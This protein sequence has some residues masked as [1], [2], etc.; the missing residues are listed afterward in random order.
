M[1]ERHVEVF[2]KELI[3]LLDGE[4]QKLK[5]LKVQEIQNEEKRLAEK[6]IRLTGQVT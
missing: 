5:V 6:K 3:S 1:M 4:Y 2:G